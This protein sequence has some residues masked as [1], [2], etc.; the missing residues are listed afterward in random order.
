METQTDESKVYGA[1]ISP[2]G[3]YYPVKN[4]AEHEDK[5]REITGG[6]M[7]LIEDCLP[8]SSYLLASGWMRCVFENKLTSFQAQKL[9]KH[10]N[11]WTESYMDCLICESESWLE[12]IARS[13]EYYDFTPIYPYGEKAVK[14]DKICRIN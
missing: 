13:E 9:T 14:Y 10:Q 6:L 3:N 1:W 12:F 7:P 11:Q 8:E 4:F 5:A 2:K